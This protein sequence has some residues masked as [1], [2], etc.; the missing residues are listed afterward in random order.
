MSKFKI[1]T[2][3]FNCIAIMVLMT[4]YEALIL[5]FN[6]IIIMGFLYVLVDDEETKR[7]MSEEIEKDRLEIEQDRL[8]IKK[9]NKDISDKNED[10]T[11]KFYYIFGMMEKLVRLIKNQEEKKYCEITYNSFKRDIRDMLEIIRG[12]EAERDNHESDLHQKELQ[13]EMNNHDFS[14]FQELERN[15]HE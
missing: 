7:K 5:L 15:N 4:N 10:I 3:Y 2:L 1:V 13:L 8:E 6:F 12:H 14:D 11:F 9:S